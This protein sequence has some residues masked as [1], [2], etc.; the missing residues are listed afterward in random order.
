M[1]SAE[2]EDQWQPEHVGGGRRLTG[3]VRRDLDAEDQDVGA[4]LDRLRHPEF[5]VKVI[6]PG[7]AGIRDVRDDRLPG[8]HVRMDRAFPVAG[9]DLA[10]PHHLGDIAGGKSGA[11]DHDEV[12]EIQQPPVLPPMGQIEKGVDSDKEKE[13]VARSQRS[14]HTSRGDNRIV[15]PPVRLRSLEE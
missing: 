4:G 1:L 11:R 15:V 3:R 13:M 10:A 9:P 12:S 7:R 2:D 6:D 14:P 8:Q 5:E